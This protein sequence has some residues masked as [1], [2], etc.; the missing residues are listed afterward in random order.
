MKK[1]L[2]ISLS[3]LVFSAFT[4]R[5]EACETLT[6]FKEGTQTTMTSYDEKG[7]E[8]GKVT[9]VF[10][11][12]TATADGVQVLANQESFDKKGNSVGKNEYTIKCNGN[13]ILMDMRMF[14]PQEQ[15]QAFKDMDV[16]VEGDDLEIPTKLDVG[17]ILKDFKIKMKISPKG[18]SPMPPINMEIVNS[19]RKVEAIESIT[20]PSGTYTCLKITEDVDIKSMMKMHMKSVSWF[21]YEVGMVKTEAYKENGKLVNTSSLTEFKQP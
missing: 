17:S 11:K 8:T 2:I 13:S 14:L 15:M 5:K 16:K 4:L 18:N 1:L 19:N 7:K 20:T 21:N 6:F 3:L 12:V 10:S 9:K